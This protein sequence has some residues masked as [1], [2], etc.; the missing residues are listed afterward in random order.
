MVLSLSMQKKVEQA[1]CVPQ[2]CSSHGRPFGTQNSPTVG[3]ASSPLPG[4]KAP[5]TLGSSVPLANGRHRLGSCTDGTFR[6]KALPWTAC[7]Q[8]VF[9]TQWLL[10]PGCKHIRKDLTHARV[11]KSGREHALSV[12]LAL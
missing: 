9:P 6:R 12:W 7:V 8:T 5:Q 4:K 10:D 1:A 3:D 2:P 11:K